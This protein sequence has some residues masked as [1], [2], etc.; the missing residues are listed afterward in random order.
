[1]FRSFQR[2]RNLWDCCGKIKIK[3]PRNDWWPV[4]LTFKVS[5]LQ[6]PPSQTDAI[7]T[8]SHSL[9]FP[10]VSKPGKKLTLANVAGSLCHFSL[11]FFSE[12]AII[13]I[14][15]IESNFDIYHRLPRES[16]PIPSLTKISSRHQHLRPWGTAILLKLSKRTSLAFSRNKWHCAQKLEWVCQALCFLWFCRSERHIIKLKIHTLN[17]HVP[18]AHV[19]DHIVL[20]IITRQ[21]DAPPW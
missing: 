17:L 8:K 12:M 2:W 1:M 11:F 7:Q 9:W 10:W 19:C 6:L 20:Y 18:R 5:A 16:K 21:P 3:M 14:N 15:T 4:S 13:C